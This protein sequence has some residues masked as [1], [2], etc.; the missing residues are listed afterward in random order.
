MR[1]T[2]ARI[3]IINKRR[4]EI[5]SIRLLKSLSALL[6]EVF[7]LLPSGFALGQRSIGSSVV[8]SI[9]KPVDENDGF[10]FL[11]MEAFVCPFA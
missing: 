9:V 1:E 11:S 8:R 4:L 10:P 3:G 5:D 7:L 2:P 6:P